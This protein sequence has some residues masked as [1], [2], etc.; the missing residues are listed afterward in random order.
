M[1]EQVIKYYEVKLALNP[2]DL[3]ASETERTRK[4][5]QIDMLDEIKSLYLKG[6]PNDTK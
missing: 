5:A 1:I 4:L 6:F 2:D 3:K